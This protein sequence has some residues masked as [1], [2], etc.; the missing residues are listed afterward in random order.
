MNRLKAASRVVALASAL[1]ACDAKTAPLFEPQGTGTLEGFIFF[2]A[3]RDGI[4]DPSAGDSALRNVRVAL[5]ERGT[6]ETLANG[7]GQTGDNGRFIL[8]DLR[9]GTHHL[10]IDT[11]SIPAGLR[12]CENPVPV[13]IFLDERQF[14]SVGGRPACVISI[15]AAEKTRNVPVVIQGIVTAH[16]GQL[17]AAGD[18]TYVEDESGGIR[19]FGTALANR[20]L[21]IG[22]RIEVTGVISA[23]S[24]DLQLGG[25]LTLGAIQKNVFQP[26]PKVVTTGELQAALTEGGSEH[27]L[28]GMLVVIRKARIAS[29][30]G[31]PPINGRNVRIDSG[32]GQA[33]MRIENGV[34]AGADAAAVGAQLTTQ[35]PVGKCYD[36]TGVTGAFN[37]DAQI[38]PRTLSDIVEV[39]CT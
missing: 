8:S 4:F 18:Y 5:Q 39:P 17:R 26:V 12:F 16:A 30:F 32:N 1:A 23:F 29:V 22:D 7:S 3:D 9:P 38:F 2:D 21:A 14:H 35:Y 15:A 10:R 34:V 33:Q 25:T 27:P 13:T 20:G 36:I 28:L 19:I 6:S 31:A 24:N 11:T 37:P